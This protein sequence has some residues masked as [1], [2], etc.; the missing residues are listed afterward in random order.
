MGLIF[1]IGHFLIVY[2]LRIIKRALGK[3]KLDASLVAFVIKTVRIVLYIFLI[4]SALNS[5]GISTTGIIAALSAAAVAVSLA[6]KDSLSNVAG[7]IILLISPRFLTGDVIETEAQTGTVLS[8]DLMHTTIRTA[9]NKQISIPNGVLVNSYI[10][11]YSREQFRRVDIT[12]SVS[13]EAD[14][15]NAKKLI[16]KTAVSHQLVL[17]EP[18]PPLVRVMNYGD[19]AVN[20]I[21]RCWCK[22]EDYWTVYFDLTEHIR[23]A[24]EKEGVE[25]PY[26][27]IVVHM[28]QGK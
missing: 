21:M 23:Y 10:T 1:V 5:I 11:N 22:M 7:G 3:S 14:I 25:I 27:Q 20:V 2:I 13:Y 28:K 8:V 6:L 18:E 24:L 16:E 12:F 15:E 17:T 9:D 19:S 26:N 4:M